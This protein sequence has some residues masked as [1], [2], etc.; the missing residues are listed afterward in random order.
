MSWGLL[1]P[2]AIE[3]FR[4]TRFSPAANRGVELMTASFMWSDEKGGVPGFL[5]SM[6]ALFGYR[7]SLQRGQPEDSLREPWDQL[8]AACPEWPGF[9]PERCSA[10]LRD[11][12]EREY[13]VQAEDFMQLA[14]GEAPED[15]Q[16]VAPDR[17]DM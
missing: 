6:R 11:E 15:E 17:R 3:M 9:R 5:P 4:A 2:M 10:A 1:P 13:A 7:G 14:G 8:L 16:G 12:L